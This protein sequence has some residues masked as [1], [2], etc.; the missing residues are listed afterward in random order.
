MPAL[1]TTVVLVASAAALLVAAGAGAAQ[2]APKVP[3]SWNWTQQGKVTPVRDQGQCEDSLGFAAAA[4]VESAVAIKRKTTPPDYGYIPTE[5]YSDSSECAEFRT[6]WP[7]PRAGTVSGWT[8]VD[9]DEEAIK[10]A[11]VKHGPVRVRMSGN[12]LPTYT[13]GIFR[14]ATVQLDTAMVVVG[15]GT[16]GGKNYWIAKN[17]FGPDWGEH[18]YIKVTRDPAGDCGISKQADYPI[19]SD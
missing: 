16:E 11:V 19:V 7:A 15:Y 13:S 12:D 2:A 8:G 17:S 9:T 10:T 6:K 4:A 18:G 3:D 5:G 14:C 1:R